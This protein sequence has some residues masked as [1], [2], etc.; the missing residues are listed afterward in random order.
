M[1]LR[2]VLILFFLLASVVYAAAQIIF[3]GGTGQANLSTV[4]GVL[5]AG[6][7]GT[8]IN[9]TAVVVCGGADDTAVIATAVATGKSVTLKNPTCVTT[10]TI[11]PVSGQTISGQGTANT[12]LSLS[13]GVG[14]ALFDLTGLNK[15]TI[16]NMTLDG[17]SAAAGTNFIR[18]SATVDSVLSDLYI[19]NPPAAATNGA[20]NITAAALRNT[21]SRVHIIGAAGN[22]AIMINGA[23]QNSIDHCIIEP[24]TNIFGVRI[25]GV[26]SA[27]SIIGCRAIG[28]G[29]FGGTPGV[30]GQDGEAYAI[31]INSTYNRIVGNF[32]T[33]RGDNCISIV[34]DHNLIDSNTCYK[35]SSS[36]T[37][38]WGSYNTVTGNI[39][40]DNNQVN[41]TNHWPCVGGNG[42]FGG[43]S[44]Y[45]T[46]TG[47]TCD[48]DQVT[49]TQYGIVL[50]TGPYTAW[51]TGT[52]YTVNQF[53]FNGLNVYQAGSTATSGAT[54]PTCSSGTCSDGTITWTFQ[55]T[56]QSYV[57]TD[58]NTIVGNTVA[59]FAGFAPYT[60]IRPSSYYLNRNPD[61]L[62]SQINANAS[63]TPGT[64]GMI[65]DGWRYQAS[66]SGCS[67]CSLAFIRTTTSI[68]GQAYALQVTASTSGTV[69]TANL[70]GMSD[71]MEGADTTQLEWG[72][73]S[74][75]PATL[76]A[77]ANLTGATVPF[78]LPIVIDNNN[79]AAAWQS[80]VTHV[81]ITALSTW[82][83]FSLTIP[84]A[85]NGTWSSLPNT[86]GVRL[87]FG[88][89][90]GTTETS[91]TIGAW[92][93]AGPFLKGTGDSDLIGTNGAVLRLSAIHFYPVGSSPVHRSFSEEWKLAQ[94]WYY[95]TFKHDTAPAQNAGLAGAACVRNPIALGEPSLFLTPPTPMYTGTAQIIT[96]YNPSAANANWRNV[97]AAADVTVTVD[98]SSAVGVTGVE[99]TTNGT[100]ATLGDNLC[101]HATINSNQ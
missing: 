100:V 77:C 71:N 43:T 45:N 99:L 88:F 80:Y 76:E 15:V 47:N 86:I 2:K 31:S 98:P 55:F 27:N 38:L 95:K 8:G 92:Q 81:T 10:A 19:K 35:N 87:Q 14:K 58:F 74:A 69:Q 72:T 20:I 89:G 46:V 51:V 12:T 29:I 30:A 79:A 84:P 48:D 22:A 59:R 42:N 18:L 5:P 28:A 26:S 34:G 64:G 50:S 67:G 32:G 1:G 24:G 23:S 52:P 65:L 16:Q 68:P 90:S 36:G 17:T 11:V 85:F 44:Q 56:Y 6:N 37:F 101:I 94:H 78:L 25:L 66:S 4:T 49:P 39:Y 96:T 13:S 62:I 33:L 75:I 97:T 57:G 91:S 61:M 63:A 73:T 54:P 40:L 93:T 41:D 70:W 9:D 83:C 21:V 3:E 60:G 7:G 53:V 82:Q